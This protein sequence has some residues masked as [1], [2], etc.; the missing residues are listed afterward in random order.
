MLTGKWYCSKMI[1]AAERVPLTEVCE[2]IQKEL[3]ATGG[4]Q[5]G[6]QE[7]TEEAIEIISEVSAE[8]PN[9]GSIGLIPFGSRFKGYARLDSDLDVALISYDEHGHLFHARNELAKSLARRGLRVHEPGVSN[10]REASLTVSLINYGCAGRF[11]PQDIPFT[12]S[13]A[14]FE[15]QQVSALKKGVLKNWRDKSKTQLDYVAQSYAQFLICPRFSPD[16]VAARYSSI[17]NPSETGRYEYDEIEAAFQDAYT[18]RLQN[19]G[20]SI[21]EKID[22]QIAQL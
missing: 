12:L 19:F 2:N 7:Q 18:K 11:S 6:V 14:V 1:N 16:G 13:A 21:L 15:G 9:L 5:H 17:M 4:L 8:V 3:L 10:Q 22:Q 20:G